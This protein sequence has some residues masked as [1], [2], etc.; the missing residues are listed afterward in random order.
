MPLTR[1]RAEEFARLVDQQS[2]AE[3]DSRHADLLALVGDLRGIEHPEPRPEF[4]SELRAALM[5][6]ADA[7]LELR[8]PAVEERLSLPERVGAPRTNRRLAAAAGAMAFVGASASMAV[9]AQ[10][11]LPGDTLYPVKRTIESIQT[12]IATSD[13]AR[14]EQLLGSASRRLDETS[15]LASSSDPA[16]VAAAEETLASFREQ[17]G[18]GATA[19]FEG[20]AENGENAPVQAVR[21]FTTQSMSTLEMLGS[22]LPPESR[23]SLLATARQLTELDENAAELCPDCTGGVTEIPQVLLL[24]AGQATEDTASVETREARQ[25]R[26][27]RQQRR[28]QARQEQA[29]QEELP[30]LP[31]MSEPIE[32]G[33]GAP[34]P[35]QQPTQRERRLPRPGETLNNTVG[36]TLD[37]LTKGLTGGKKAGDDGLVPGVTGTVKDTVDGVT[38]VVDGTLDGLLGGLGSSGSSSGDDSR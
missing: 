4:V 21:D 15:Q 14:G 1:R 2:T 7:V 12:G 31:D 24:S 6:E 22:L 19:I 37:G 26:R 27:E 25:E 11:S 23:E 29:Q 20:Y 18:E 10:G 35:E 3:G 36:G 30:E 32:S 17:A 33:A 38:G 8:D 28:Q 9:A 5:T 34:Q 13:T 16:A